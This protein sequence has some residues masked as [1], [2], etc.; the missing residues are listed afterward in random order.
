M[1]IKTQRLRIS[2]EELERLPHPPGWKYEYFGGR[3]HISPTHQSAMTTVAVAPR[4]VDAPCAIRAARPDDET[5]LLPAYL[6]AFAENQAFCDFSDQRYVDAAR[7]DLHE[8]FAGHRAPLL[9]ASR[10]AFVS[11]NA[12]ETP[13]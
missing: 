9:A 1:P 4:L 10:V 11:E 13:P 2:F 5:S 6:E 8:S 7:D 3:A 12:G